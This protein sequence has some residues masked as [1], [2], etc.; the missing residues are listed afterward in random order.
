MCN[1]I[2][3]K[4]EAIEKICTDAYFDNHDFV[5]AT[6]QGDYVFSFI[7]KPENIEINY[8]NQE[9]CCSEHACEMVI[10]MDNVKDIVIDDV[11]QDKY[12][13]ISF[14]GNTKKVVLT[15]A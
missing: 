9:I 13:E 5:V 11:E 1:T 2:T 15:T 14:K 7:L 3:E 12:I 10:Q 6:N 4:L 8:D